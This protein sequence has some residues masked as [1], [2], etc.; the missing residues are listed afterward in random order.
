MFARNCVIKLTPVSSKLSL[1]CA[2]GYGRFLDYVV[3]ECTPHPFQV[4][5]ERMEDG[6]WR[7]KRIEDGE[8]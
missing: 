1:E 2:N 6:G 5:M 8:D 4:R 7:T 3:S